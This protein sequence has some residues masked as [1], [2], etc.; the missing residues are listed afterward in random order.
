MGVGVEEAILEDLA[1][2]GLE[3][4]LGDLGAVDPRG[5]DR[6]VIGDLDR[7]H[8]LEREH[9]GRGVRPEDAGD[10]HT[11]AALEVGGQ[12]LGVA[13]F[14]QVVDLL[15]EDARELGQQGGHVDAAAD[16][17]VAVQPVAHG[18]QRGQ[19]GSD[20]G[21]DIGPL[22]LDDDAGGGAVILIPVLV[23]NGQA[24]RGPVDLAQRGG[25]EGHFL[26]RGE[27]FGQRRAQLG[28]GHLADVGE[29]FR[30]DLVLQ[31]GQ[32]GRDLLG[33]H[34]ETGGEELSHLDEYP[35]HVDRQRAKIRGDVAQPVGARALH[36][37]AKAQARQDQ[38]PGD[39][40]EGDAG[41]EQ[42][43]TTVACTEHSC[44]WRSPEKWAGRR[45][46]SQGGSPVGQLSGHCGR[47]QALD[48][49]YARRFS[50]TVHLHCAP[51]SQ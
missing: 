13:P 37:S 27:P 25:G 29:G 42:D 48:S 10:A 19:V 20:D 31:P 2:V 45:P 1:Q 18:A 30:G 49:G 38:L 46:T 51:F 5:R 39:Q 4:P 26:E 44:V 28:L 33:E 21:L 14:G 47:C 32:L 36:P 24:E 17:R 43:D 3:Q 23:L 50:C 22:D 9:A 12:R 8:V 16:G 41:E 35:T 15:V 7:V 6:V 34:V 11:G 40:A